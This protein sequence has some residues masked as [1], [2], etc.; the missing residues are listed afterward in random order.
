[1]K[2]TSFASFAIIILALSTLLLPLI[3]FAPITR[4]LTLYNS[5]NPT[6]DEQLVLEYINRGRANPIAEG[7]RLGIDIHEGLSDP[8]LVGPRPPLAMNPILLDIA[9]A[10]TQDMYN[11][12]YFSHNDPNGTTPFD[13]MTHAGYNYA[14]AGENMAGGVDMTSNQLED[15]MMV[16]SGTPGRPHRVNLLDIFPYPCGNP[17]CIYSEIGIG[18]L[19]APTPDGQ[20]LSSLITQDFGATGTAGPFL[21][22]VVYND[23][24]GNN[25]YDIG[26][27]ISG[28]TITPNTGTYYAVSSTSGGYAIPIGTSGTIT[29]TASGPGFGPITKTVTLTG[30]NIKVDFTT[31]SQTTTTSSMQT[32]TSSTSSVATTSQMATST[33][34]APSITINPISATTGSIIDITGS[35]FSTTDVACS[36]S[37]NAVGTSTCSISNGVVTAS[38]IVANVAAGPYTIAASGIEA[39]DSASST[40]TVS[41]SSTQ[42]TTTKST[43][44]TQTS[45]STTN[46]TTYSTT[47]ITQNSTNTS[48][49]KTPDFLL[50]SST[51]TITMTQ[52]GSGSATITIYP[53]NGFTSTVALTSS[54]IG[55]VPVGILVSITSPVTPASG[56]A[57]TSPLIVTAN[58]TAIPGTYIIQVTGTSNS[59][60]HIVTVNIIVQQLQP[61]STSST[62]IKSITS[63]TS[64][65][66]ITSTSPALP[67]NC[68]VSYAISGSELAPLAEELRVFRDQSITK[69]RSGSAFMI[70]FNSWYYS[71]TPPLT[72]SLRLHPAQRELLRY[73]LYPLI[74]ILYVSRYAYLFASPFSVEVGAVTAGIVTASLL[75]LVYFAPIAYVV[76]RVIRRYMKFLTPSI[77]RMSLWCSFSVPIVGVA[78]F[79]NPQLLGI[80]IANLLFCMLTLCTILGIQALS[81]LQLRCNSIL[82]ITGIAMFEASNSVHAA[83]GHRS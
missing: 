7:Q 72:S 74:G 60:L 79:M 65:T 3:M 67:A 47:A 25:F 66:S 16:D 11:Q 26:E 37:G 13:R 20:G 5:G 28:V 32:T 15:F 71:F 24:N 14:M 12:N 75:G 70:L 17:P 34:N 38:F 73:F 48:T 45:N 51:P 77:T 18:Y 78:Y 61:V 83:T 64:M 8:S 19:N 46:S 2:H 69:T 63:L 43:F 30:T 59:Q 22:G 81:N 29:V 82:R 35:G 56:E 4:A 41:V 42:T 80:A 49:T 76:I 1:M 23:L 40:F 27:G 53:L 39:G 31:S 6:P 52:G 44:T 58:T 36:L 55:S 9:T 10:H 50:T 57:A 54:W 68:P 62:T 33:L 21:L